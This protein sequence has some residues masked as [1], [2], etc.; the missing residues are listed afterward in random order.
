MNRREFFRGL[1]V[2]LGAATLTSVAPS[3]GVIGRTDAIDATAETRRRSRFPNVVLRTQ[4]NTEVR[5]YDDLLR[6]KTVLINFMYTTCKDDCLLATA[7]LALVQ[8]ILGLRMGK[9]LFLYS[10]TLDPAHDT[11]QALKRYA[12]RF[13]VQP[14]WLFLTG[15]AAA[16]SELRRAFGDDPAQDIRRSQHL[17]MLRLGIEP[18][19]RWCGAPV[20]NKPETIVRY[21]TWME[22]NKQGV[23]FRV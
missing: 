4:E 16:T 8:R 3:P 10:I 14:G 13:K 6:D 15:S 19:E 21:L 9:D 2:T 7:N 20:M 18:L 5:F 11:P 22:P 1:G 23:G 12:L 17:N